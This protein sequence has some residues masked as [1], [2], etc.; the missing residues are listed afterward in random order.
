MRTDPLS[1]LFDVNDDDAEYLEIAIDENERAPYSYTS[2]QG[3]NTDEH[4]LVSF[5]DNSSG[6]PDIVSIPGFQAL[7]GLVRI[8]I[9]SQ[10]DLLLILDVETDGEAF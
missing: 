1:N 5:V 9:R 2:V 4:Q 10:N 6:E 3:Y 7:C 8:D